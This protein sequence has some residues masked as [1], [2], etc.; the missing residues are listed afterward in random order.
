MAIP[1]IEE[2][3]IEHVIGKDCPLDDLLQNGTLSPDWATTC[4]ELL[5]EAKQTWLHQTRWPRQLVAAIHMASWILD[6]RYRA[7]C[8]SGQRK[9]NQKTEDLLATITSQSHFF[10]NAPALERGHCGE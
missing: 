2:R 1:S 7:W 5:T 9:R 6:N 10:L 8:G 4:L 3:L